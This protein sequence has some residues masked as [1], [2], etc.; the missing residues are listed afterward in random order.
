[1]GERSGS[2]WFVVDLVDLMIGEVLFQF[3]LQWKLSQNYALRLF[4]VMIRGLC[5]QLPVQVR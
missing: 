3:Q 4:L 5:L 2:R 1:M